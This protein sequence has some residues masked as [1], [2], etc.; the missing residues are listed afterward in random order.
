MSPPCVT[1]PHERSRLAPPFR[2]PPDDDLETRAVFLLG[3]KPRGARRSGSDRA[4][5]VDTMALNYILRLDDIAPNMHWENLSCLKSALK[6]T[7]V[8][9][10]AGVVPD[11]RDPYLLA[12][13]PCPTS[14]WDEI[15]EMRDLG[16]AIA[17]HGYQH[18]PLTRDG[19]VL[20][21][22]DRSEFAGLP[23]EQQLDRLIL[24]RRILEQHGLHTDV[25]IAPGHSFDASTIRAL[26][27]SGFGAMSD[28]F[29]LYPYMEH[30]MTFVPQLVAMPRTPPLPIGIWTFC[31]HLNTIDES[32]LAA[33]IR[34]LEREKDR[35]IG[36]D[37]AR[38]EVSTSAF[39]RIAGAFLRAAAG[40]IARGRS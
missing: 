29:A 14:F 40:W 28:G 31:L 9:P 24:G 26:L 32:R 13:P 18:L 30:G 7:G 16:W 6:R 22:N 34:F 5:E 37:E 17:M 21:L 33:V 35:F 20:G 1:A 12:N 3:S 38:G 19:G 2:R 10:V 23:Y 39:S 36:F 8:R 27:E 11:N 4:G 25:F 15:R